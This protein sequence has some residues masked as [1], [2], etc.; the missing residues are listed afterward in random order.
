VTVDS[1][2]SCLA[3]GKPHQMMM[4]GGAGGGGGGGLVINWTHLTDFSTQRAVVRVVRTGRGFKMCPLH[5]KC[6]PCRVGM[7]E[8]PCGL[9][10]E[11][12]TVSKNPKNDMKAVSFWVARPGTKAT[13]DSLRPSPAREPSPHLDAVKKKNERCSCWNLNFFP[14]LLAFFRSQIARRR[15]TTA[16]QH[17]KLSAEGRRGK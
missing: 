4:G 2:A 14:P 8:L 7:R 11:G 12:L 1:A 6:F 17:T 10:L 3:P 16:A 9:W 15:M 5:A 13:R